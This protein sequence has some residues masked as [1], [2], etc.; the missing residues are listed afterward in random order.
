MPFDR[1]SFSVKILRLTKDLPEDAI[2]RFNKNCAGKLDE[3]K[4]EEPQIGWISG[5]H[6]L[7]RTIEEETAILG[8]H[9]YL[10]LRIAQRKIPTSLLKA[11]MK[12]EEL[13]YIKA[14]G[15]PDV[16][17]K[18]KKD[19]KI[20]VEEKR[21]PQMVPTI[22]GIPFVIDRRDNTIYL[23]TCSRGQTDTFLAMFEKTF[24]YTPMEMSAKDLILKEKINPTKYEGMVLFN[25]DE[26][27]FVP[28]RDFLTWLWYFS[29]EEKGEIEVKGHGKFSVMI[30]GPLTFIADGEGALEIAVKKGNPLKSAEAKAA[31]KVGKKIKK[32]KIIIARN[33]QT[34][35]AG[36]DADNFT[37]S[38]ITLP[39]GEEME[40]NSRFAERMDSLQAFKTAF[41]DL[42]YLFLNEI[43][44]AEWV[45]K[46]E[47]IKTWVE[48]RET[49]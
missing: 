10:N 41:V 37:F 23:G 15:K 46:T 43:T 36:F 29:E 30:D 4:D 28:G 21:L 13:A 24:E 12:L 39:E 33:D 20:F 7:E 9:I 38:G 47:K 8:G 18:V 27:D 45:K 25:K 31:L 34:W 14:T 26:K 19:I 1:G 16:P 5:R 48:K 17:R 22:T 40:Y 35:S 6:L 42:F 32:S 3:V 49:L 2:E 11:E 44:S